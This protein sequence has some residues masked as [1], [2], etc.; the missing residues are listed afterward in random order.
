MAKLDAVLLQEDGTRRH[1]SLVV[2][3][4]LALHAGTKQVFFLD[5]DSRK[6]VREAPD[7]A[8]QFIALAVACA[9]L[10][11]MLMLYLQRPLPIYLA[12][13]V[14]TIVLTV[15]LALVAVWLV[16]PKLRRR[17]VGLE[18]DPIFLTKPVK[19]WDDAALESRVQIFEA[20]LTPDAFAKVATEQPEDTP[21][22]KTLSRG[23]LA[24]VAL[25]AVIVL[26]R[27]L[28]G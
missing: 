7:P 10:F 11:G 9:P 14:V 25:M 15:P 22:T 1:L 8:K 3:G 17:L 4:D 24:G 26:V 18:W 16:S 20:R 13:V 6:E 19:Q 2:E 23:V 28:T 12:T 21:M 5:R 27:L